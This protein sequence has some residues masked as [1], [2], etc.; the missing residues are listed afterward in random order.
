[1]DHETKLRLQAAMLGWKEK[2]NNQLAEAVVMV[3]EDDQTK[4]KSDKA[5]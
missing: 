4:I 3:L 1:M 5:L 2:G